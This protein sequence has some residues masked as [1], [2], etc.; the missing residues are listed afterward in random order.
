MILDYINKDYNQII[1]E[2]QI[3]FFCWVAVGISV[4]IDLFFGIRKSKS[5]GEYTHSYGIRKTF[6]KMTFYYSLMLLFLFADMFNPFGMYIEILNLP[7][8]TILMM[9]A[10]LLTEGLSIREK[11][12]QKQRRMVD[13]SAKQL[14]DIILKNKE[15]IE[16][17]KNKQE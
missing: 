11:A 5:L 9:L 12:D 13:K 16:E 1:I 10:L 3:I 4:G 17:L 8:M 7:I 15:L 6:E 14:L 2:F